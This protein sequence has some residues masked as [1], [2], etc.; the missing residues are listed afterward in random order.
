MTGTT[1]TK[2]STITVDFY[3]QVADALEPA[4]AVHELRGGDVVANNAFAALGA[5][6]PGYGEETTPKLR[7]KPALD[8]AT[9]LAEID[10]RYTPSNPDGT[11]DFANG[12]YVILTDDLR[13]FRNTLTT[14]VQQL[15]TFRDTTFTGQP[16]P[17]ATDNAARFGVTEAFDREVR[18]L[19]GR[20]SGAT[21]KSKREANSLGADATNAVRAVS[22]PDTVK[23]LKGSIRQLDELLVGAS[24]PAVGELVSAERSARLD[25]RIER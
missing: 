11:M 19:I 15:D 1:D 6:H 5:V 22:S 13:G 23:S 25:R 4:Y 16:N 10:A 2:F 8:V 3:R 21:E 9:T 12:G 7:Y 17:Q 14:L 18:D 20:T 24:R